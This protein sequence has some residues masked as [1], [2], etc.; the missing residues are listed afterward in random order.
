MDDFG[1]LVIYAI[2]AAFSFFVAAP[3]MLNAVSTFGVQRKFASEMVDKGI[4][5]EDVVKELQPKKQLAGI[6]VAAIVIAAMLFTSFK[7]RLGY[8]SMAVGL[9]VGLLRFRHIV[10]FNNLTVRRFQNTYQGQ[11]DTA[12]LNEYVKKTF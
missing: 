10:Q 4:I 7:I 6:I 9:I 1:I 12:K 11:Y 3:I 8:I 5:N 2:I